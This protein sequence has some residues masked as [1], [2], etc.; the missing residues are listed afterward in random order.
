[1]WIG[2]E[3]IR[4]ACAA[5]PRARVP[6]EPRRSYPTGVA[7][8]QVEALGGGPSPA[9]Q[10]LHPRAQ[11]DGTANENQAMQV[12]GFP[13]I[14]MYPAGSSN[15]TAVQY[16]GDRNLKVQLP[17]RLL[18]PCPRRLCEPCCPSYNGAAST[19]RVL[20]LSAPSWAASSAPAPILRPE[21]LDRSASYDKT[22]MVF[23]FL[24]HNDPRM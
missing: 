15:K 12:E 19:D 8:I 17:L 3:P 11:I 1:M 14:L 20:E 9:S 5:A 6:F 10:A 23:C 4:L 13:T 16:K 18:L 2:S 22:H 7:D 24:R 21:F